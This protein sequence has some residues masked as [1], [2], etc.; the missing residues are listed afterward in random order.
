MLVIQSNPTK[1]FIYLFFWEFSFFLDFLQHF[2]NTQGMKSLC[3]F[4]LFSFILAKIF[5]LTLQNHLIFSAF[6][7]TF[8][9]CS[10]IVCKI[11]FYLFINFFYLLFMLGARWN[12]EFDRLVASWKH[13]WFESGSE[14]SC[15]LEKYLDWDWKAKQIVSRS[16]E[17]HNKWRNIQRYGGVDLWM[18][19][20]VF[21]G[22]QC[23]TGSC[24]VFQCQSAK[25]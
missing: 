14:K 24:D 18:D 1:S 7:R 15:E 20:N 13:E 3:G 6:S 21:T 17:S 19:R 12:A 22:R 16:M 2:F 10:P 25:S 4:N 9:L 11:G 5:F 8:C 23:T